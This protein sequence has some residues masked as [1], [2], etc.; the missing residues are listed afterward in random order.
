MKEGGRRE[1]EN[2]QTVKMN[3]KGF[4]MG[5]KTATHSF[6]I[7]TLY[8]RAV[9]EPETSLDCSLSYHLLCLMS[10]TEPSY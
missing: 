5:E 6:S 8:V 3:T 1:W 9:L 7:S 10:H 4:K 2:R